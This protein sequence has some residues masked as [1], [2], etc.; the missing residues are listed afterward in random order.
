M[1]DNSPARCVPGYRTSRRRSCRRLPIRLP[2]NRPMSRATLRSRPSAR[3]HGSR[4]ARL[5]L[6]WRNSG[7]VLHLWDADGGDPDIRELEAKK[8]NHGRAGARVSTA[9]TK[10][11][12][13]D[14]LLLTTFACI[15]TKKA[16]MQPKP[17]T[18]PR[19]SKSYKLL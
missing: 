6:D 8:S 11:P 3:F 15:Q 9:L 10:I 16:L 17:R 2:T 7:A 4:L 14:H 19:S 18:C 12:L 5:T 13:R 1:A